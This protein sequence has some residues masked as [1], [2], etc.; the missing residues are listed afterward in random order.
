MQEL[1]DAFDR[2][3]QDAYKNSVQYIVEKLRYFPDKQ[4]LAAVC[5]DV[6]LALHKERK[7]MTTGIHVNNISFDN[8]A[9]LV[10]L[11]LLF[12]E[13]THMH[14]GFGFS[15]QELAAIDALEEFM[16]RQPEDPILRLLLNDRAGRSFGQGERAER[17]LAR[18]LMLAFKQCRTAQQPV[19]TWWILNKLAEYVPQLH[20]YTFAARYC[21]D[22]KAPSPAGGSHRLTFIEFL[23]SRNT[24]AVYFPDQNAGPDFSVQLPKCDSA[25]A[26]AQPVILLTVQS[27]DYQFAENLSLKGKERLHAYQTTNPRYFYTQEQPTSNK[28]KGCAEAAAAAAPT[29]DDSAAASPKD[30]D[31]ILVQQQE[32][33]TL[34]KEHPDLTNL[35]VGLLVVAGSVAR[36]R[37]AKYLKAPETK[38]TDE[39]KLTYWIHKEGE[40][41]YIVTVE[42]AGTDYRKALLR[43]INGD[44]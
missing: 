16:D 4:A 33:Q 10:D 30:K 11:G 15:V 9:Q 44:W 38:G 5:H 26:E 24:T 13:T 29:H 19:T 40:S 32:M 7:L 41:H 14:A 34:L 8:A 3:E 35:S 31:T 6:V 36:P 42:I 2:F 1:Q 17:I 18:A 28:P 22:G 23:R 43:F 21:I 12:A 20:H 27:K 25:Q 37:N 39:D